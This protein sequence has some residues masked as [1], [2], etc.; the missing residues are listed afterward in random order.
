MRVQAAVTPPQA[1]NSEGALLVSGLLIT[2]QHMLQSDGLNV[3]DGFCPPNQ[4]WGGGETD[5]TF[6]SGLSIS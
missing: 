4:S 5:Q 2:L 3:N 1:C 6:L